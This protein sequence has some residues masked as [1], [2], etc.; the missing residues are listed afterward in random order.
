MDGPREIMQSVR[1]IK[2]MGGRPVIVGGQDAHLIGDFLKQE[3]VP[4]ILS[5]TQ[6]L[7]NRQ[8]EDIDGPFRKPALL[9]EAGVEFAI[10]HGGYWEQR[11]LPFVAGQAVGF[12]L[13]KESALKAITLTPARIAGIADR[14]GSLETGKSATLIV[15]AGD[16]LDMRSSVVELAFIDGREVNLDNKQAELARKFREKYART[17]RK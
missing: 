13:D 9:A 6:A 11:N 15:V 7:P 1:L 4:V 12:G 3:M 17:K 10:S 2:E 8:D 5:S 16:V 14:Y